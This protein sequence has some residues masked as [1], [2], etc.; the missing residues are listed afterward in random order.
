MTSIA[1][2]V[3]PL[4]L[5]ITSSQQSAEDRTLGKH[6]WLQQLVWHFHTMWADDQPTVRK[7]SFNGGWAGRN[8]QNSLKQVSKG[9]KFHL[10]T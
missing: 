5:T 7:N 6:Q 10:G 1:K 8:S 3:T 2:L 9:H 4:T